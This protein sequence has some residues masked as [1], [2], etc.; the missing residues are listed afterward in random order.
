LVD[1]LGTERYRAL[2]EAWWAGISDPTVLG[3]DAFPAYAT[4]GELA[5]ARIRRVSRRVMRDGSAITDDSPAEALHDLRKRCKELRYLLEFF[6]TLYDPAVIAWLVKA[7]KSLQDNL[8]EFQD[9]QVQ[10]ESITA[11]AEQLLA[12]GDVPAATFMA[13]GQVAEALRARQLR[14]RVEFATRFATFSSRGTRGRFAALTGAP[15]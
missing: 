10:R 1:H 13:M 15:R 5:D 2:C 14:A 12:R 4:I 9:S 8:G 11:Y 7:M 3:A 6:A